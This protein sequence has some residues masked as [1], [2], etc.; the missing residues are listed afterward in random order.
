MRRTS[1]PLFLINLLTRRLA[2]E[3]SITALASTADIGSPRYSGSFQMQDDDL[4][5]A[6]TRTNHMSQADNKLRCR[7]GADFDDSRRE[8][9]RHSY[10]GTLY[11]YAEPEPGC[12]VPA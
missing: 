7:E 12:H 9:C 2:A 10:G 1:T 11:L 6:T 3:T 5:R 4:A 8:A